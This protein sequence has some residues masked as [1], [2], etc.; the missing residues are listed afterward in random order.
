MK[1]TQKVYSLQDLSFLMDRKMKVGVLGGTFDPAHD[2]HIMISKRAIDAYGCDY[3]LWLVAN[4]NPLK[5]KHARSIFERAEEA[6]VISDDS[7]IIVT[8][9]EHDLAT[10]YMYDSMSGLIKNF[11]N[12]EFVWMMGID[13]VVDFPK[14]HR[15]D[16]IQKLC[17]I[18][19]F[20]RPCSTRF[21]KLE[22]F[23]LKTHANLDNTEVK[24]IIIDR[25]DLYDVSSSE[26]R[27]KQKQLEL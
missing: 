19:I 10:Q 12:V 20:D 23:G 21:V 6:A 18:I 27:Q 17:N 4:Q 9:A 14:W 7:R 13:N 22:D 3:V 8:T 11:Q 24:N 1:S 25:N 5:P 26:I 2:G 15:S 16:E